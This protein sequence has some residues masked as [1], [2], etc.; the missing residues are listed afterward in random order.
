[1]AL[2]PDA[3]LPYS[4]FIDDGKIDP[5][6]VELHFLGH[7]SSQREHVQYCIRNL[8][9][10]Q[11]CYFRH[12][13][14]FGKELTG[15]Q[16]YTEK[17]NKLYRDKFLKGEGQWK[18]GQSYEIG[19]R[20]MMECMSQENKTKN[21]LKYLLVED[22]C[23]LVVVQPSNEENT[24]RIVINHPWKYVMAELDRQNGRKMVVKITKCVKGDAALTLFFEN[25]VR[26]ASTLEWIN[27][28]KYQRYQSEQA[29]ILSYLKD[30]LSKQ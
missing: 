27:Q 6:E 18:A 10:V 17:Y 22:A 16:I 7:L 2:V 23:N 13:E 20:D 1:M 9:I 19:Y 28:L 21:C 8:A 4:I 26:T 5:S 11:H 15:L 30:C 24:A 12:C 25:E 3:V 29:F 14:V